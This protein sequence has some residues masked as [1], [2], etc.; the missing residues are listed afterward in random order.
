[1]VMNHTGGAR[2]RF[3]TGHDRGRAGPRL[4]HHR[5]RQRRHHG[6]AGRGSAPTFFDAPARSSWSRPATCAPAWRSSRSPGIEDR[7]DRVV[8]ATDTP[9]GTGVMPLGMI[10]TVCEISPSAGW[11][12]RRRSP[13][14]GNNGAV[15]GVD[16]GVLGRGRPAD[17]FCQLCPLGSP[18]TVRSESIEYGDIPGIA[19]VV[20]DGEVRALG[21]RETPRL[22]T[23]PVKSRRRMAEVIVPAREARTMEVK[24]GQTLEIVDL[25]GQ[26][27]GAI[28]PPGWPATRTSTCHPA[29]R[30]P[31]NGKPVPRS[32]TTSSPTTARRS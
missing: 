5:P 8:L 6:A 31:S 21:S 17:L 15:L 28:S 22:P 23:G 12:R 3:L 14:T 9:T 13:A 18:R 10:K 24:K 25:E 29:T 30:F 7:L 27:V 20:I 32:G 19:A 26:Q 2:S 11:P 1:M 16:Q 4:R